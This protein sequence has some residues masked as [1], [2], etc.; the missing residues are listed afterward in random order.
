VDKRGQKSLDNAELKLYPQPQFSL[1]LQQKG[2][3][4]EEKSNFPEE[5]FE[6]LFGSF[7]LIFAQWGQ[8]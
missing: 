3:V 2:D 8:I 7:W 4:D 6:R 5:L 1:F